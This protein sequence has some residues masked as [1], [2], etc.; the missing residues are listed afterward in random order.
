M[1]AGLLGA[2][3][4]LCMEKGQVNRQGTAGG[5]PGAGAALPG[6]GVHLPDHWGHG[7]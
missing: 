1:S 5:D 6:R 2:G 4:L 3:L 7:R